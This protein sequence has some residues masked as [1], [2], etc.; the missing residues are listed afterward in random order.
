MF[1]Q[2]LPLAEKLEELTGRK[3]ELVPEHEL[4]RRMRE[5]VLR[6]AAEL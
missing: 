5:A 4:N 6:E 3:V 1:K 2:R